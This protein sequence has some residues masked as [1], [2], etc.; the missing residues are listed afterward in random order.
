MSAVGAL[1]GGLLAPRETVR[2][3]THVGIPRGAAPR[4]A[5]PLD[6]GIGA[7]ALRFLVPPASR[8]RLAMQRAAAR[9]TGR[10]PLWFA[11]T[12]RMDSVKGLFVL[13]ARARPRKLGTS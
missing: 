9:L 10:A 7:A 3:A 11:P 2:G 6:T 1:F 12:P 4:F 8:A 13:M 5:V